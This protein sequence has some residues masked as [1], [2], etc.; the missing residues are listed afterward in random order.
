MHVYALINTPTQA[1][2]LPAGVSG[3]LQL[4]TQEAIA[5]VVE[6]DLLL[7]TL[8]QDDA[9]LLQAVLAHDRVIQAV[10]R[11]TTVLPLRFTSF[12]T[13]DELVADLKTQQHAYL[14]ALARLA[15][16]VEYCIQFIPIELEESSI[17]SDLK[18]KDYF[19]AKK[20]QLQAQQQQWNLQLQEFD[21]IAGA[22]ALRHSTQINAENQHLYVLIN[23]EDSDKLEREV[24]V[25][26]ERCKLWQCA[27]GEALPPFHFV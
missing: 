12:P 4:V 21:R 24:A 6:P 18:G 22:I 5:A 14:T 27:I 25:L 7:E 2:E 19:L 20:R 11:Q 16:K 17:S 15:R 26:Q 9:T 10:F 3:K 8:Q 1:L 23:Q 13:L